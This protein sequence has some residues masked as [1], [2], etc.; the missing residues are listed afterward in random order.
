MAVPVEVIS[1]GPSLEEER[2]DLQEKLRA[3]TAELH[4]L[5]AECDMYKVRSSHAVRV[6]CDCVV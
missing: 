4:L 2:N 6:G 5:R 1:I 3:L